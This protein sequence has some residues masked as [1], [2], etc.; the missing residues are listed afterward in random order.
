MFQNKIKLP[1]DGFIL[2][3]FLAITVAFLFPTGAALLHVKQV[4]NIGIA[5]IFFFYGLKLSFEEIKLGLKNYKLHVLIQITTFLIFPIVVLLFKPIIS[6]LVGTEFW[7]GLF[8]LAALP[9]TVSSSVVMVSLAKG[10]V[11]S[12]IF[13]ASIS[14][15][16]GVFVTPIWISL[17]VATTGGMSLS[18]VFLKLLLQIVA[19]LI[20]GVVLNKR[21]GFYAKKNSKRIAFFD[22]SVIVLIVYTSFCT[23]I[24]EDVFGGVSLFS[25]VSLFLIIVLLFSLLMGFV[26]LLSA[27][28]G[29]SVADKI[30]ATFCG[31]KKSLVHGSAMLKIIFLNNSSAGLYLLPVMVYHITQLIILAFVAN[32]LGNRNVG[33]F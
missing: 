29:F 1:V 20:I 32:R 15:I 19:P 30:T 21:I 33:V 8:F 9:S 14:G 31:S 12:A 3:L 22:K 23:S 28:L 6:S 18:D 5:C 10:N 13:N 11:P 16:I 26:Y 2:S 17:F 24:L 27:L 7:I 4:T 25:L